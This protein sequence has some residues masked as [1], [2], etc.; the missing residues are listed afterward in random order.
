MKSIILDYAVERKGEMQTVYQ[1]DFSES[2]NIISINGWNANYTSQG[3]LN[4]CLTA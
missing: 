2:L 1:Y 3:W 4:D